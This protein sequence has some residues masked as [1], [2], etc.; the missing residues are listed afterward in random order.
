MRKVVV[1]EFMTLDG[2]IEDPGGAE[3]FKYGGWSMRYWSD[4]IGAFKLDE[5][6][7]SDAQLLGR[8]TYEGFAVAW[9]GQS[10]AAGFADRM[11]GM[12]KYVVST[13]LKDATWNNSQIISANVAEEV[14]KLKQQDGG[15]ILIAGSADLIH[16]LR[17]HNLIDRYQLL[18]YPVV[19]GEGKRLFKDGIDSSLKLVET[20]PYDSGVVLVRYEIAPAPAASGE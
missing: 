18:I 9:P 2:V 20:R 15:D 19:L 4:D 7:A 13:T 12:P 5:L 16:F 6:F 17:Q 10:D 3:G 11:N 14:A 1:T 8:V